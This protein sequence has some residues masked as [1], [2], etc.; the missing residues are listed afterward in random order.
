M[1]DKRLS[2]GG[3]V[4]VFANISTGQSVSS[5]VAVGA[6]YSSTFDPFSFDY[7]S[8]ADSTGSFAVVLDEEL[9]F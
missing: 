1:L 7:V 6:S 5:E 8:A 3:S 2:I 9:A 4:A